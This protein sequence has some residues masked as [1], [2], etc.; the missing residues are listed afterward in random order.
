MPLKGT[1]KELRPL[2]LDPS[3]FAPR[4][5]DLPGPRH[6]CPESTKGWN[7]M[8]W[9]P[10]SLRIRCW[11]RIRRKPESESEG[12][13]AFQRCPRRSNA[14]LVV[15]AFLVELF[16]SISQE[17]SSQTLPESSMWMLPTVSTNAARPDLPQ[18][19]A[20]FSQNIH[21]D[22]LLPTAVLLGRTLSTPIGRCPGSVASKSPPFLRTTSHGF[23]KQE[24]FNVSTKTTFNS[25]TN[26]FRT[27]I[28]SQVAARLCSSRQ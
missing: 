7:G 3:S 21:C 25:L 8:E 4:S 28:A 10:W 14:A 12:S 16:G 22:P 19:V 1:S 24:K 5:G 26:H 15:F 2:S 27:A 20:G 6:S 23:K 13:E 17:M 18:D 11:L 9:F